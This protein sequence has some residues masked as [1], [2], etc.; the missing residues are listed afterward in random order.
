MDLSFNQM[1]VLTKELLTGTKHLKHLN[2]SHNRL[3]DLRKG[4]L[5]NLTRLESLDLSFNVLTDQKVLDR[6][7]LGPLPNLTMLSLAGNKISELPIEVILEVRGRKYCR[8]GVVSEMLVF[9]LLLLLLLLLIDCIF[10][11]FHLLPLVNYNVPLI[12]FPQ[13][14]NLTLL[15]S[16]SNDIRLYYPELT[17]M[18]K[19]GLMVRLEGNPIHCNCFLR[20]VAYWL[21]S[22]GR[23][24][25]F[26]EIIPLSRN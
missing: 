12:T 22:S 26:T 2:V 8:L 14:K 13:M 10:C 6:D 9:F 23:V 3:N 11:C 18:I 24:Q 15:D 7:R 19:G 16:S 4:V 17:G 1:P 25:V 21:T 5:T 20:P